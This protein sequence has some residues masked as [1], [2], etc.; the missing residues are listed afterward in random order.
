MRTKK[1]I[2]FEGKQLSKPKVY[3]H[4]SNH[5]NDEINDLSPT[6]KYS[7]GDSEIKKTQIVK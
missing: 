1:D 5:T 6:S 3:T 7:K 4:K 2:S